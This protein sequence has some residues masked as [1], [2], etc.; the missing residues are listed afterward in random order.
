[1]SNFVSIQKILRCAQEDK[2]I[3]FVKAWPKCSSNLDNFAGQALLHGTHMLS[4]GEESQTTD[5]SNCK[6]T[7]LSPLMFLYG[8]ALIVRLFVPTHTASKRQQ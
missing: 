4:P 6:K 7:G 3:L 5:S 2:V 1:M 8:E